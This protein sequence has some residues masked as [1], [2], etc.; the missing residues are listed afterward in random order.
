METSEKVFENKL[1]RHCKKLGIAMHKSHKAESLDNLGEYMLTDIYTNSVVAGS[2]F[3]MSM[4][5]I[6]HYLKNY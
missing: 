5:E 2:R 3:D 6:Q 4:E 1:R